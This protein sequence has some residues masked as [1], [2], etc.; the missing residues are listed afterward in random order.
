MLKTKTRK[1]GSSL[2]VTLPASEDLKIKNNQ[3]L[4]VTYEENGTIILAPKLED[5]FMVAEV[6]ELYETDEW[7]G[8]EPKGNEEL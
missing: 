5:P 4:I 6:G 2:I 3:E 8:I 7:E 1:Q